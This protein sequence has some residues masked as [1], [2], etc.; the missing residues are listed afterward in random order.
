M[1]PRC[2]RHLWIFFVDHIKLLLTETLVMKM[3]HR[4]KNAAAAICSSCRMEKTLAA[5]CNTRRHFFVQRKI[6]TYRAVCSPM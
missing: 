2:V 4:Y 6:G 3:V 1:E 5:G